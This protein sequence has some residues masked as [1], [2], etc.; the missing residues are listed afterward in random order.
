[1]RGV[2]RDWLTGERNEGII[3]SGGRKAAPSS[4]WRL[5]RP[6]FE[7]ARHKCSY[8]GEERKD[9]EEVETEVEGKES[10]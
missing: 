8:G 2:A 9:E 1:M 3:H 6:I 4:S 10:K 5:I 7:A